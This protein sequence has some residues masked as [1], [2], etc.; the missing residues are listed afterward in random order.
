MFADLLRTSGNSP[1]FVQQ[2]TATNTPPSYP[3]TNV[4]SFQSTYMPNV[5]VNLDSSI[6]PVSYNPT[7]TTIST[8]QQPEDDEPLEDD[9][10]NKQEAYKLIKY[11]PRPS[12]HNIVNLSFSYHLQNFKRNSQYCLP[13]SLRPTVVQR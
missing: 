13:S 1:V 10:P 11:I 6:T 4:G 9:D 12:L 7:T 8:Q 5:N 3:E 2:H